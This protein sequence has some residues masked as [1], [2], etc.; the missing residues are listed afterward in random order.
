MRIA[1]GADHRGFTIKN[2]LL[3]FLEMDGHEV[4]DLGT[5]S[6]D[7]VDYPDYAEKVGRVVSDGRADRGILICGSGV[8]MSIAANKIRG[9]KAA[10][11]RDEKT[12]ELS[13]RHNDANVLC[14]GAFFTTI[15][16]AR[17]IA[18]VWLQTPFEAGRHQRRVQKISDIEN[19]WSSP[20]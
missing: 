5:F 9:I 13:R 3:K 2:D 18:R 6:E 17:A 10:L 19:I 14:I 16:Q 1:A 8:G 11:C 4:L 20:M 7:P 12:A 15:E